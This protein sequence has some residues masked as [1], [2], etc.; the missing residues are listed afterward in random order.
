LQNLANAKKYEKINQQAKLHQITK[1]EYVKSVI[2]LEA[3]AAFFRCQ[4]FRDFQVEDSKV[5][6]NV[7]YL[8]IYDSTNGQSQQ[9]IIKKFF[10]RYEYRPLR[11]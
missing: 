6:F 11:N 1:L 10:L 2:M 4:V 5:P 9:E 3:E 7:A 8:N